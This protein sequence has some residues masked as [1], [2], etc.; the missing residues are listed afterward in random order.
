MSE[1][2]NQSEFIL[3]YH[4]TDHY[5]R[6]YDFMAGIPDQ[7]EIIPKTPTLPDEK[8][9]HLRA[10]LILEET[11]EKIDALGFDINV[12][13]GP[14]NRILSFEL[15]SNGQP[16]LIK[17]ID[18]CCDCI[19][20]STGTLIACGLP[21][22]PFLKEVDYNNQLK[23]E[24]GTIREDGKFVK[25]DDHPEPDLERVLQE[26]KYKLAN[27]G[28]LADD[29]NLYE[30]IKPLN[31]NGTQTQRYKIDNSIKAEAKPDSNTT[32]TLTVPDI[33]EP[34][35]VDITA[36]H[37]SNL[38]DIAIKAV[39]E[40]LEENQTDESEIQENQTESQDSMEDIQE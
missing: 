18:G 34:N 6:V 37:E 27:A 9:R 26:V 40:E 12:N 7:A 4:S 15:V 14:G 2:L 23:I 3:K 17:I 24:T 1:E 11:V 30:D 36:G 8:T 28:Q 32:K 25:A 31:Y 19:V 22:E 29:G 16:D 39:E 10:N 38:N 33:E 35:N 21:D 13:L 5:G 20:I